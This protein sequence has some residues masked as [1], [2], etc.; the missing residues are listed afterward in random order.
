[1]IDRRT[2]LAGGA[3]LALTPLL[4]SLPTRAGPTTTLWEE[5]RDEYLDR[6]RLYCTARFKATFVL[7]MHPEIRSEHYPFF[8]YTGALWSHIRRVILPQIEFTT[9]RPATPQVIET[10]DVEVLKWMNK[11]KDKHPATHPWRDSLPRFIKQ[12]ML[13]LVMQKAPTEDQS[14]KEV[15]A[16]LRSVRFGAPWDDIA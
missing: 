4:P 6:V 16:Y 3:A 7:Y 15:Q 13:A 14:L 9:D 5:C 1:M 8:F 2:L 10:V 12:D 11:A